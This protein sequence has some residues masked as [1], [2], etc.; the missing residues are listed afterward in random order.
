MGLNTKK[1][2]ETFNVRPIKSLG[3][4]FL[5][6]NNVIQKIISV[7]EIDKDDV[8]VEVGPGVGSLTYQL[9]QIGSKIIAVEIDKYLIPLLN[10]NLKQFSNVQIINSDILKL[11]LNEVLDSSKNIKIISNLPY[12]I[13]TP[14]IMKFIEEDLNIDLMVLMMQKEVARRIVAT[15]GT[16]DYG[17]LS[18]IIQ[19]YSMPEIMFNVSNNC[20]IPKPEVESSVIKLKINKTPPV[21]VY[22]KQIFFKTIKASFEQRRKTLLNSLCNSKHFNKSKEEMKVILNNL[23]INE[24]L[25]GET[26][27]IDQFANL[28]NALYKSQ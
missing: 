13:T 15:P 3:Q 19:Y 26:L 28:S 21:K 22:N 11:N 2:I 12:Y 5:V 18:V 24:T 4:N 27:S 20:F 25:R 10:E 8:I 17:V 16:K 6:D 23:G 7:S 14:V 1:I 9:A